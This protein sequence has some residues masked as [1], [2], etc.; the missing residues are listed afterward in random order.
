MRASRMPSARLSGPP[1]DYGVFA[2]DLDG[3]RER[4]LAEG[5][6]TLAAD[7]TVPGKIK[8]AAERRLLAVWTPWHLVTLDD[9]VWCPRPDALMVDALMVVFASLRSSQPHQA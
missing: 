9:F 4:L 1:R 7:P 3:I 6:D 2:V 8:H 5:S